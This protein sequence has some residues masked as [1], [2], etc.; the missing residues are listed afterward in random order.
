M[1]EQSISEMVKWFIGLF[2]MM[3]I[4]STGFF[5]YQVQ[6]INSFKQQVNY[7]IERNGGLT[8]EA[9][10]G[11][12]NYSAKNNKKYKVTSDKLNKRVKFGEQVDYTIEATIPVKLLPMISDVTLDFK[13]NG[14]SQIR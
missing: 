6:D 10:H 13:G 4:F 7:Q 9:L 8:P 5:C 3:I 1:L 2:L 11:I 12:N 14:V